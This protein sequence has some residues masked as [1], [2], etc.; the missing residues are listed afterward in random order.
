MHYN[1]T[2]WL[3]KTRQYGI[4]DTIKWRCNRPNQK[5]YKRYWAKWIKCEWKTF[6]DFWEDMKKWYKD[7]LTIDRIN[8]NWNYCKSN[9]KWSTRKEQANNRKN[10]ILITY[11]WKTMT[12]TQWSEQL[13]WC[14]DLVF[15][16]LRLWWNKLDAVSTRIWKHNKK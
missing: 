13:W 15:N 6:E 11:N 1:T 3:T 12:A 4:F 7:N 14:R 8:N 5:D 16:R 10:N 2:H 9:C